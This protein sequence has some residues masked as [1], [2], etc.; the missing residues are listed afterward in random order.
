[1][2]RM[3]TP[4]A[5]R[6]KLTPPT[7]RARTRPEMG[8]DSR[9][10]REYLIGVTDSTLPPTGSARRPHV[11]FHRTRTV[12]RDNKPSPPATTPVTPLHHT[13]AACAKC[14]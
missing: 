9:H 7:A 3:S 6:A 13:F 1:M 10:A 11:T 2:V 4:A 14:A 12:A 5:G 8:L